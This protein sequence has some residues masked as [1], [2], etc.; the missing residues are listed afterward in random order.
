MGRPW[1]GRALPFNAFPAPQVYPSNSGDDYSRD[2]AG[3]TPSKPPSTVYPGAFYMAG[4]CQT[5]LVSRTPAPAGLPSPCMMR[6]TAQEGAEG[7]SAQGMEQ[8]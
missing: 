8:P 7:R 6:G 4:E 1:G 2:P 5:A 3:Y